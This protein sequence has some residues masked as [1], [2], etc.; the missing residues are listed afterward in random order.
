MDSGCLDCIGLARWPLV[1]GSLAAGS[2]AAGSLAADPLTA[3][4]LAAK[5]NG[6][7]LTPLEL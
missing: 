6:I 5:K 1:D 2:L 3:G 4:S 7:S